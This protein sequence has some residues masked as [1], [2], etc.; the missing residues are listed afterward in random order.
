MFYVTNKDKIVSTII[1]LSTVLVLF[2][3]ATTI[4]QNDIGNAIQ[5]S[6]STSKML[7]IYSVDTEENKVALTINCAWNAEDIDL[8]VEV[9]AKNQV[10]ATFFIVGD[11]ASKFPDAVKKIS[12][13]GNEVANH[14]ESHAHV[15]NLNYEKN[16]EQITK[17]S[18]RINKIT[19]KPTTLY[20]GPYG[21]YNNTVIKAAE[22]NNHTMIQWNIDSLDY[23]GLTG[24][25]MWE[26]IEPKL[27]KGSII[28]MHNGTENT[29]LSLDMIINN[30]KKKGYELVTVSDL[31][32]KE[33]YTIDNNG[34]QHEKFGETS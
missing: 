31:I 21:E 32:Y 23:K 14:S 13:S 11:W 5:T 19:G 33:E 29:A 24:E 30:I 1:S 34:V 22:D 26:R 10:K 17:C 6:A 2:L 9:L 15:N 27:T 4:K 18:D 16:V 12:D 20:R 8:I 25:Q 7:P 28:L 3:I